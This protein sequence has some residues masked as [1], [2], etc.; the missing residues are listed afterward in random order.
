MSV[1][2]RSP[3]H[4]CR[5]D[6]DVHDASRVQRHIRDLIAVVHILIET[7]CPRTTSRPRVTMLWRTRAAMPV[8]FMSASRAQRHICDLIAI[9]RNLIAIACL[10]LT[11]C[12]RVA[13]LCAPVT[14]RP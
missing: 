14:L 4:L 12:R 3:T 9:V 7:A 6:C 13:T 5:R 8:T 1:R 2:R 11:S 10:R